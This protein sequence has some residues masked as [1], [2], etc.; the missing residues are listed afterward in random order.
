[1]MTTFC[2]YPCCCWRRTTAAMVVHRPAITPTP[3]MRI[4][5]PDACTLS[6]VL[7]LAEL[8]ESLSGEEDYS[9]HSVF[10]APLPWA[11]FR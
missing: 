8:R 3:L 1:M 9:I 2:E 6:S 10:Y 5:P 11:Q 7:I 4:I